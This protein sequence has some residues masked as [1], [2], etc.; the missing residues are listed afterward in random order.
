MFTDINSVAVPRVS[1]LLDRATKRNASLTHSRVRTRAPK[2]R[3]RGARR[4]LRGCGPP[5][6]LASRGFVEP[7]AG[8]P[9][10]KNH[11]GF[12]PDH[13]LLRSGKRCTATFPFLWLC[14]L[15][16]AIRFCGRPALLKADTLRL[17]GHVLQLLAISFGAASADAARSITVDATMPSFFAIRSRTVRPPLANQRSKRQR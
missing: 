15:S 4:A 12:L 8:A 10:R 9:G 11:I 5:R 1:F 6:S 17:A 3:A 14:A 7:R 13:F 16:L 2:N